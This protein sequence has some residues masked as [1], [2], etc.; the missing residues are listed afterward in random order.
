M[1]E[2]PLLV[3][4]DNMEIEADL[5]QLILPVARQAFPQMDEHTRILP[6]SFHFET[7]HISDTGPG[8]DEI[9]MKAYQLSNGEL[10]KLGFWGIGNTLL[11]GINRPLHT[12]HGVT[13]PVTQA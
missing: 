12:G 11:V 5:L 13:P 10:V 8:S 2:T 4:E 7:Y 9:P 1:N 6:C 3:V